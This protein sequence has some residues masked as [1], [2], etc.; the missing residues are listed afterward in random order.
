MSAPTANSSADKR[1]TYE[2]YVVV[3]CM[4]AYIFSFVDRQVLVLM[5][6][7]IKRDLQLSD[8]QFSLL[9]GFAFSLFYA[10]MGMPIAYLADRYAR[11]QI[12]SFGIALWSI[13]TATCGLSQHFL[14]MFLA[15]MGVGVGEAAL[16]PGAYSMLADYFPQEKLGRAI[17][18]YSLGSFIG[19]GTAF[20]VG[21]YVIALLKHASAFTL[22]LV[23]QVHAWQVTFLIVGL[24]GLLVALLFAATVRDPQRKGLAQDHSGSIRRVSMRDSLR[25]VAMHRS[26]FTCHYL[27]FS[28]YAMALYCLLSWT[29]AFYIRHFGMTAVEAGYTLGSVLLVANTAGVFCGGWLNDWLLRRGYADAPMRAGAIGAACMVLPAALFTQVDHL[30]AS[31][32]LLVVAMFFGSFPMPTSTA[33]MQ[34]LAPNQMRAQISALFLLVSNIIGLGIGTTVVALFT[35]RVFGTPA[36]VG[37]SMSLVNLTTAVLAALLLFIGRRQYCLSLERERGHAQATDHARGPAED[38]MVAPGSSTS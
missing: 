6:E 3:I 31:L 1:Y 34:T 24:P 10:V 11:P 9:N 18:V 15:R 21:G 20:L 36:A 37:H 4:L 25:F 23:G 30:P 14:Q 2:W 8:T 12:I 7:P 35:D 27:G 29:P 19:G 16:S 13:A 5:I 26:T 17:A 33:A 32:A 28:C 38:T 22:P